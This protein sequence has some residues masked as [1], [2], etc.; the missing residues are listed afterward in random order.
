MVRNSPDVRS[1]RQLV[2]SVQ[3]W[4]RALSGLR[5]PKSWASA[6]GIGALV[7]ALSFGSDCNV[8][9]EISAYSAFLFEA[10]ASHLPAGIPTIA[11]ASHRA[12]ESTFRIA[13]CLSRRARGEFGA[14][15]NLQ[16]SLVGH[17]WSGDD[18][19][20]RLQDPQ[21]SLMTDDVVEGG[22]RTAGIAVS[23]GGCNSC[24]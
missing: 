2:C 16:Q 7:A 10:G 9:H 13:F 12:Q 24:R 20:V 5:E 17:K 21:V 15:G 11:P 14:S 18:H 8:S 19:D 22:C 6:W 23:F 4:R 3:N 1:R